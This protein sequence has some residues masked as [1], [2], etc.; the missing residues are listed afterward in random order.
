MIGLDQILISLTDMENRTE[1][2][3]RIQNA[4][5]LMVVIGLSACSSAEDPNLAGQADTPQT[6]TEPIENVEITLIDVLD[7]VT[8]SYCLDIAGGNQNIDISNGLQAHT[9]YSYR[10]EIGTDQKFDPARFGSNE[11]YMPDFEVCATVS[12]LAEGASIGLAA[13]DGS[14][15]QTVSFSGG[16]AISMVAAP[17]LC[18]TAGTES[19]FGR[20]DV[21]QIKALSLEA[22]SPDR[23]AY[24]MW[25]GRVSAE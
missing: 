6:I 25:R 8:S 4:C 17:Q 11:L 12:A 20:S 16:G 14:D 9:C 13:C 2:V 10:G 1:V 7:G 3:M 21:H 15:L 22:C 18:F 24:Q 23:D 19:R 5:L